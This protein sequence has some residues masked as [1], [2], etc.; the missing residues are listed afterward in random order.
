[1]LADG[2]ALM[3]RTTKG[4]LRLLIFA[5]VAGVAW[6]LRPGPPLPPGVS[7]ALVFVSDREGT[8]SLYWRRL[9][10]DRERRLTHTSEPVHDPRVS[11]DGTQV[12]FAMGGRIGCVT[13]ATADV[14]ML[15][16]GVD[17]RDAMPTWR[18]DGKALVVCSRRSAGD[19][20]GLHLLDID[21]DGAIGRH[22]L[23]ETRGLDDTSPVVSP[24]GSF[25]VFVREDHL[26]RVSLADGRTS[27]LTGGFRK[28]RGPRFLP[29]GRLVCLWSEGKRYGIDRLDADG[30]NR[31]TLWQGPIYYRTI[32]PSPDGR[33][34]AATF[35]YDLAFHPGDALK[36]RQTEELRLLDE[37][38]QPLA[39]LERSGRYHNHSPDWGR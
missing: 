30:K 25:V 12:A 2:K 6:L 31:E 27:R 18:P 13:V 15:T 8:E 38:G 32:A 39:I 14:R 1:L 35:T 36:L 26:W 4:A 23:T 7:G 5:S 34:L 28:S 22:P 20:V 24:D 10:K 33:F 16:L 21:A 37:Q 3:S 17:W 11:P 19:T 9:P 29:S